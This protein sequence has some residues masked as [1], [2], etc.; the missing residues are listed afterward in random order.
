MKYT[1]LTHLKIRSS[2]LMKSLLLGNFK[3]AFSG[4]G[5]EF[6]DFRVYTYGDDAKYIDWATSS[7][8]GTTVIRRYKEEKEAHILCIADISSSLSFSQGVK[9]KLLTDTIELIGEI[10]L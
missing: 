8:E 5:I 9:Q 10:S 2:K 1:S 6:Q 3:A 4:K 7:R